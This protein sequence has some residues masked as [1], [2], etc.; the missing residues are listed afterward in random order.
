MTGDYGV[1]KKNMKRYLQKVRNLFLAFIRFDIQHVPKSKNMRAD[2]LSNFTTLTPGELPREFFFE[3]MKKS[4]I[5]QSAPI[6]QVDNEP[7]W[8]T[9]SSAS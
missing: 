5:E 9:P 2:L 6:L 7:S 4:S 1:W 3:V 8:M